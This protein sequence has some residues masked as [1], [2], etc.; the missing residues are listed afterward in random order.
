MDKTALGSLNS[1]LRRLA[2]QGAVVLVRLRRGVDPKAGHSLPSGT[3]QRGGG[4]VPNDAE[5]VQG[6]RPS[7]WV[8]PTSE[9]AGPPRVE[10]RLGHHG[11]KAGS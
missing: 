9:G 5:I 10:T 4:P 11:G 6:Y 8:D 3:E 1:M 7:R 2:S